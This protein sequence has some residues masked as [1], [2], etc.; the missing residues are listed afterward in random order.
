MCA[1]SA[2]SP[3]TVSRGRAISIETT[4]FMAGAPGLQW[5]DAL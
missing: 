2:S 5:T 3:T 4:N 1:G